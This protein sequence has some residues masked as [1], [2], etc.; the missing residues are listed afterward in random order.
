MKLIKGNPNE[1]I[2]EEEDLLIVSS[3]KRNKRKLS[4]SVKNGALAIDDIPFKKIELIK[5]EEHAIK[6]LEDYQKEKSSK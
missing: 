6:A 5:E 4:I 3:L 2:L 1:V